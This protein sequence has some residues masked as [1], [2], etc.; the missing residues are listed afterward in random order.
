MK[1]EMSRCVA[2]QADDPVKALTFYTDV[3]G[4]PVDDESGISEIS[5]GPLTMY[6]DEKK[7]CPGLLMELLVDDVEAARGYLEANGCEVLTWGGAGHACVIRDPFGV[8]YNV[9]QN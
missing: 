6:I 3:L 4:F 8:H 7:H 1:F 9:F 2:V 5:A